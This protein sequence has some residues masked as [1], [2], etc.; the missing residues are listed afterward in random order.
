MFPTSFER[1]QLSSK[2]HRGYKPIGCENTLTLLTA[3][4]HRAPAGLTYHGVTPIGMRS[5]QSLG[6][7]KGYGSFKLNLQLCNVAK[8]NSHAEE[9]PTLVNVHG[10]GFN[11]KSP[12]SYQEQFGELQGMKLG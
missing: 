3:K 4:I 12:H 5:G 1:Q 7:D 9:R 6:G 2:S 8:P 10:W 11:S